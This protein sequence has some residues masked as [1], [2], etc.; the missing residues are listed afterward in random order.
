MIFRLSGKNPAICCFYFLFLWTDRIYKAFQKTAFCIVGFYSGNIRDLLYYSSFHTIIPSGKFCYLPGILSLLAIGKKFTVPCN[1]Y[2]VSVRILLNI[3]IN[4]E[5]NGAHNGIAIIECQQKIFDGS[6]VKEDRE[7]IENS[8]YS[9][10]K[11]IRKSNPY[12]ST[13]KCTLNDLKL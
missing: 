9:F 13:V 12:K 6:F 4:A 2:P 8:V 1:N 10:F 5:I 3:Y 11:M 7:C